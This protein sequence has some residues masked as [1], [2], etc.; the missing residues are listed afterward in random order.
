[1][2]YVITAGQDFTFQV[3]AVDSLNRT[4]NGYTNF[5]ISM[6]G[7]VALSNSSASMVLVT[8]SCVSS[9]SAGIF[10]CSI[11]PQRAS[12]AYPDSN[13]NIVLSS[14]AKLKNN[15]NNFLKILH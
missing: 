10:Q 14:Y 12:L 2:K 4:Y 13:G 6:Q 5:I 3:T 1:M 11:A 7:L 15:N 8:G 9:G